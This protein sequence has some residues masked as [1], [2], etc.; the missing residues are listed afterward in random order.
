[1][2][3]RRRRLQIVAAAALAG[4]P[5]LRADAVDASQPAILQIFE[6]SYKT[7]EKR[8]PDIFMAG[9]GS[10]WIPPT[11][12]AEAGNLSVG[13]DAY[14]RFDL[15][16]A[17]NP[18][19]YGTE[20]GLRSTVNSLHTAHVNVYQDLIWNHNGFADKDT[21]GFVQSGGYPGFVMQTGGDS[22][23]DF[24][25]KNASGQFWARIPGINVI[26]I[27]QE[28]SHQPP[29]RNAVELLRRQPRRQRSDR[30]QPPFLSR[31]ARPVG[32]GERR[33]LPQLVEQSS[34]GRSSR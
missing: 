2:P 27:A 6:A 3:H 5:A 11:N 21:G 25:A 7:L 22:D 15:G 26:D 29:G 18:T 13:Y 23:G 10:V 12:R 1:M 33:A 20:N 14:D 16:S 32:H 24:H 4:L 34:R 8:A 9:Y 31:P 28:K 30:S 17:G 19:L